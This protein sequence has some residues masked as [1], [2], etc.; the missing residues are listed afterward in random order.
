MAK[1]SSEFKES[2][3]AKVIVEPKRSI[4]SVANEAQ[5]GVSSLHKWVH[6]T[7]RK[8]SSTH[9]DSSS[10]IGTSSTNWSL[11]NKLQAVIET[12]SL[13]D[14]AKNRYCR[15]QGLYKNQLDQWKLEF[16]SKQD[17]SAKEMTNELKTL[18]M[19]NK[20]L[21]REL[22]RKEKALAE[23][24]ALLLLKKNLDHLWS[25]SEDNSAQ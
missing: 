2:L 9:A 6:D 23:A 25:V 8:T 7:I 4:R 21:Q 10:L 1:F 13:S 5:V 22:Q 24:S 16:M 11:A 19:Q 18:R 14:D 20:Q 3:V 15:Q 17:R 12:A